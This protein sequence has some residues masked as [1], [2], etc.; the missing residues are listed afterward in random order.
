VWVLYR[1]A[2][3]YPIQHACQQQ[4][5]NFLG[6]VLQLGGN[7]YIKLAMLECIALANAAPV[8]GAMVDNWYSTLQNCL[9]MY[10]MGCLMTHQP[11]MSLLV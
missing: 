3:M 11:L 10:P 2:G 6:G 5:L 7:E 8:A 9:H 1:E 4:M